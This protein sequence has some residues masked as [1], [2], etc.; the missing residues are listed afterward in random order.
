MRPVLWLAKKNRWFWHGILIV[1]IGASIIISGFLVFLFNP[2]NPDRY[3]IA[4]V[5]GIVGATLGGIGS[6]YIW[7]NWFSLLRQISSQY[8]PFK[9]PYRTCP[10]CG[11]KYNPYDGCCGNCGLE[12]IRDQDIGR[13]AP[14]PTFRHQTKMKK[15]L[16]E[17]M[18]PKETHPCAICGQPATHK[19]MG[20]CLCKEHLGTAW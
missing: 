8:P 5:T 14:T 3:L 2:L 6:F 9:Q 4:T 18:K 20:R 17:P 1:V 12:F 10:R 15:P 7:Y 19:V 11:A 16:A 13:S